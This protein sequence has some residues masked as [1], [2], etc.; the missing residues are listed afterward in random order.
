[1]VVDHEP[2]LARRLAAEH[3][4]LTVVEN[5]G[6]PGL[7]D[8][9]NAGVTV[10]TGDVVAFLDDDAAAAPDWL[11]R[12]LAPYADSRVL[13]VGGRVLPRWDRARPRWFPA[14]LDWV[15]GCTYAGHPD[16]GPVR[17]VIGANMSFRRSVLLAAGGF[18]ARVG[19]TGAVPSGCEETELCIRITQ[20]FRDGVIWYAPE[21][22]VAHRVRAERATV[23]YLRARCRAEGR[24]KAR[25]RALVG[26]H[27]GLSSERSYLLR[28]LPRA[29]TADLR[30]L[31]AERD[32]AAAGRCIARAGGVLESGTGFL[33]GRR[34]VPALAPGPSRGPVAFE[35]VLVTTALRHPSAGI[36]ATTSGT[37]IPYR[38]ALVLVREEGRACGAL[39]TDLPETGLG[40]D[41]LD[42]VIEQ[43]FADGVLVRTGEDPLRP[44][45]PGAGPPAATVVVA[46]CGRPDQL[47]RCLD[48]LLE[49]DYPNFDVVVVD[50]T[51]AS[52]ASR[53]V[54]GEYAPRVRW[55]REPKPGLANAHNRALVEVTAPIVAFTDDDVVV[56]AA[57]IATL[58]AGFAQAPG[59]ACVTGSIFPLEIE[60]PAQ[61]LVERTIGFNKGFVR[62]V[63]RDD[64]TRSSRTAFP[65][66]AGRFGSG[67]NMAFATD[68]L[69]DLGGFDPALGTGTA[70][71]GGDDLA[72]FFEVLAAG[73]A[74]VYEPSAV[75]FH[76]HRRETGALARQAFGYGAGLTAYLTSV[77]LADPDRLARLVVKL[78]A[79]VRHRAGRATGPASDRAVRRPRA[80]VARE[81]AG[82]VAGP[83]LYLASRR[84]NPPRP[85]GA[86]TRPETSARLV[87]SGV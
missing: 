27:D 55:V 59:V 67:A 50:N 37:G 51:T 74:L 38:R 86:P 4:G 34:P 39:E 15:V 54:V 72:A 66:T 18:D 5:P 69:R 9:R 33:R 85:R 14:E 22:V 63:F 71:R 68:V 52:I 46:T 49:S 35:P 64:G 80:L 24:S 1:M 25:V 32:L 44:E 82:M 12:L 84:R 41:A 20:R 31:L 36:P 62:R 10:A 8:A 87:G 6:R 7:S 26:G 77:V 28:T 40:A 81:L 79:G 47:R 75:V 23:R 2:A 57:W 53:R 61:D 17:N 70:A 73:H 16:E 58:V 3:P 19:R 60:T 78:P 11:S 21:A 56:D 43:A 48:S 83:F 45:G 13:G 42:R 65:F 30:I 29:T 76:A